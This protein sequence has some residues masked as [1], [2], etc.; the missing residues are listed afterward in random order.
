MRDRTQNILDYTLNDEFVVY[1]L[2]QSTTSQKNIRFVQYTFNVTLPKEY[3]AHLR[4]KEAN[5]ME[6]RGIYVIA[7][8]AVLSQNDSDLDKYCHS[9]HTYTAK[10]Q[11]PLWMRLDIQGKVFRVKTGLN[12]LPILRVFGDPNLFCIDEHGNLVQYIQKENRLQNIGMNFW[13]L[14]EYVLLELVEGKWEKK[15]KVQCSVNSTE[16]EGRELAL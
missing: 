10:R 7:K 8:N 11:C 3:V 9:F 5:V 14:L 13:E 12:A 15:E 4:G 1:P 16:I 2:V 6:G